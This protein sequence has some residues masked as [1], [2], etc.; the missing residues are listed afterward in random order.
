MLLVAALTAVPGWAQTRGAPLPDTPGADSGSRAPR[1]DSTQFAERDRDSANPS[2]STFARHLADDQR[3][4]WS[5]PFKLRPAAF[6]SVLPFAGL[7]AILIVGDRSIERQVS[8]TAARRSQNLSNYA[9]FSLITSAAGAYGLGRLTH[10]DH[11]RET[12]LL[13]G[14]AAINGILV[15]TALQ[16]AIGRE[17]PYRRNGQGAFFQ[18]GTSFPSQHTAIAWSVASIV[19][20]EYPGPLTKLLAYGLASTVT[21]TR[22]TGKQHFASDALVGSALGWYLGR[23]IYRARHNTSLGGASWGELETGAAPEESPRPP[24]RMGS[25][26]VPLDSWVYPAIERLAAFGYIRTAFLGLKP[27]TRIECARLVEESQETIE[28]TDSA[29]S[30]MADLVSRLGQEFSPEFGLFQGERNRTARLES[31]Y[32]RTVSVSGPPLTDSNHFGQTLGYDFG[33]PFRRGFNGQLGASFRAVRGPTAV[34]VRAEFQHSPSAPAMSDSVRNFI[35]T[36]DQVPAPAPAAFAAI[37]RPRLLDAYA[38]INLR[39]GWQFAFGKQSLSWGPDPGG[40]LLWSNNIEPIPMLRL[41]HSVT[42]LP[43]FLRVL[44]PVRSESFIGRLD[45]H[46]FIPHPYVYGNKI[47]FKPLPNLELGFGRTVTIGGKGGDPLTTKNFVLSFFGQTS[48]QLHSVPGDSNTS[49]D[50]TFQVPKT[51]NYLVF[52]G[53]WYADDDFVPFQ[54]P[55]K[56]PYRPGIYLTRFPGLP[57]LDFHMEAAS[58]ESPWFANRGNLNYWNYKYRDGYTS[59]GNLIG[60]TVGRMG[61][62]IQCWFNYWI[63]PQ[64]VVQIAYKHNTVSRDFVPQ[65]GAWQDYSVRHEISFPSGL[66]LKSQLQLEHISRYPLLFPGPQRNVAAVIELGFLPY[67]FK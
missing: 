55:P 25:D 5:S 54:N 3:Q 11:L 33:R 50:W 6:E 7:T 28:S 59:N 56:N 64:N 63:S 43:G 66:Y 47:N 60:N 12:G 32:L 45:G 4:F 16:R 51:R 46:T 42:Q 36:A 10:N 26:Y 34:F 39:E 53:D 27:W 22:V 20:H 13:S 57:K 19:A 67:R 37:N 15:T 61:R 1:A 23:Q 18:G 38:A 62:S 31:I 24:E 8:T 49:F 21:V 58:T 40:S 2:V 30:G 44:G 14:E 9:T 35:A 52:Y 41:T 17:R 65:G 29:G 48:S